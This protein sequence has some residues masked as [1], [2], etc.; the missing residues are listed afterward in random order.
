MNKVNN[1][2]SVGNSNSAIKNQIQSSINSI[3]NTNDIY[4]NSNKNN[5][6]ISSNYTKGKIKIKFK[7]NKKDNYIKSIDKKSLFSDLFKNKIIFF[8]ISKN[9]LK[10]WVFSKI[11]G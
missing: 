4:D 11:G 3:E 8:M 2:I 7:N 10:H 9:L 6:I 5:C 1:N